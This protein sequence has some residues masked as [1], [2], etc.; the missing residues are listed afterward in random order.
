MDGEDEGRRIL[1]PQEI[2]VYQMS[3]VDLMLALNE[4]IQK[5]EKSLYT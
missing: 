5:H 3:E 1:F 4:A 2:S